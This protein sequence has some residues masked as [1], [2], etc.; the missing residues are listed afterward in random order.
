MIHEWVLATQAGI[1]VTTIS[2]MIRVYPTPAHLNRKVADK[3]YEDVL[4]GW[5]GKLPDKLARIFN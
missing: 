3:Y 1:P 2:G 5:K 4:A